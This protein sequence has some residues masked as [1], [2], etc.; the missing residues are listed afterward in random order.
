MHAKV[1]FFGEA[2]AW[3]YPFLHSSL[4]AQLFFHPTIK[5]SNEDLHRGISRAKGRV[6]TQRRHSGAIR[7]IQLDTA[8]A[9]F[10]A[11][12][13]VYQRNNS[14]LTTNMGEIHAFYYHPNYWQHTPSSEWNSELFTSIFQR[15]DFR[16]WNNR[17]WRV[18]L[19][20]LTRQ[21]ILFGSRNNILP[22]TFC[23]FSGNGMYSFPKQETFS[24]VF[25]HV[26]LHFISSL[27]GIWKVFVSG[28]R[29]FG[30]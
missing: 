19:Y 20:C 13:L 3:K 8:T 25:V 22:G 26:S 11:R 12:K 24:K 1:V 16:T 7:K 5:M 4:R 21:T 10:V 6:G 30:K 2:P 15:F 27:T 28:K 17:V 23:L 14:I 9:V 18:K 29:Q